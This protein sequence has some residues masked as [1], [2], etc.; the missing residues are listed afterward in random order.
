MMRLALISCVILTAC[1]T[2]PVD[3]KAKADTNLTADVAAD[4]RAEMSALHTEIKRDTKQTGTGNINIDGDLLATVVLAA[5]VIFGVL[6]R[7]AWKR[8]PVP[9]WKR[10]PGKQ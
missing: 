1:S 8:E 10:A 6:L 5:L 4:L 7:W 2:P 3:V 9:W